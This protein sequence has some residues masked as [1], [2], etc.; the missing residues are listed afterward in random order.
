[1]MA[2]VF[3]FQSVAVLKTAYLVTRFFSTCADL[4]IGSA[5]A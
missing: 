2:Q 4:E 1:M 5:W 3:H